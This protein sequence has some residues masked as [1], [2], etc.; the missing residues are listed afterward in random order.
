VNKEIYE[1]ENGRGLIGD[2]FRHFPGGTE[3]NNNI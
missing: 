1:G 3:E 2:D